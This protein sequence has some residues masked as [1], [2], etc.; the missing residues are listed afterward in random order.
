[1]YNS[2][3]EGKQSQLSIKSHKLLR[4]AV[5]SSEINVVQ[6]ISVGLT[7]YNNTTVH[8][9][10]TDLQ[11]GLLVQA[12]EILSLAQSSASQVELIARFISIKSHK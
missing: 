7:R 4:K 6:A 9:Y 10:S 1:M 12:L 11:H 8:F 5:M 3:N 2:T